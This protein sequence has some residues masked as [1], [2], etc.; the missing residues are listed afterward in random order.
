MP[1]ALAMMAAAPKKPGVGLGCE[2]TQKTQSE[3]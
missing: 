1:R 2:Q 3:K